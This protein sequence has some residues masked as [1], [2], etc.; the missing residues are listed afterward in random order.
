MKKTFL[1]S[2]II[3]A[4]F[5]PLANATTVGF[6]PAPTARTVTDNAGVTLLSASS[7]VLVGNFA[8]Q[9]FT[10]NPALSPQANFTAMSAAGGWKEFTF[11][12]VTGVR[13]AAATTTY[14]VGGTIAGKLGGSG[15]DNSAVGAPTNADFFN[16]KNVY[17]W[18]FNGSTI[19]AATQMGLYDSPGVWTFP[20]NASGVGDTVNLSSLPAT[21][22]LAV[23][24]SVGGPVGTVT[25]SGGPGG[26]G[27]IQLAGVPEPSTV[28]LSALGLV[29]MASRRRRNLK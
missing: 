7:L 6:S 19:G 20:T 2:A 16:G 8:T 13:D 21:T 22:V 24:G 26:F 28:F 12:T 27:V 29:G 25:S 18:I 3:A 14:N 17:V 1:T 11:D 10:F 5:I 4:A 15:S 9:T 23:T